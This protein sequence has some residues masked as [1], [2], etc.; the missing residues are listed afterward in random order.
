LC[1]LACPT[2]EV[3]IIRIISD[4]D[5]SC[6][7]VLDGMFLM[8]LA[9]LHTLVIILNIG[10]SDAMFIFSEGFASSGDT[11][12]FASP[13]ETE[14]SRPSQ[15]YAAFPML[16]QVC[17]VVIGQAST[18]VEVPERYRSTLASGF[19]HYLLLNNAF[20][21][22]I[23]HTCYD[24]NEENVSCLS[25]LSGTCSRKAFRSA[26]RHDRSTILSF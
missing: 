19:E 3:L 2:L 15:L 26:F 25:M 5:E 4:Y 11:E 10:Y 22:G 18:P 14:E 20:A 16:R 17:L 24:L 1:P 6:D 7:V 21:A 23:L 13:R 8:Q 12:C 9:T